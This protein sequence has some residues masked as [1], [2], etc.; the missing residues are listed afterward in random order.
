MNEDTSLPGLLNSGAT[1][2]DK[3]PALLQA[4]LLAWRATAVIGPTED[5]KGTLPLPGGT[6]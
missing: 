2:A 5:S 4:T 6:S 3:Q 1:L